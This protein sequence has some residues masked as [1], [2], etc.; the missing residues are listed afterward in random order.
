MTVL[1]QRLYEYIEDERFP[2]LESDGEFLLA[3]RLQNDAEEK[4]LVALTDEQKRLFRNY[5]D[6][7]NL[8]A[9]IQLRYVFRET[10]A[11]IHD[12]LPL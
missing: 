7:E 9:S 5:S 11:M 12:I 3:Q 10:L 4:L 2:L 1:Q 6:A 8:L